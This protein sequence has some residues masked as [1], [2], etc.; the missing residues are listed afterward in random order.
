MIA[1][2]RMAWAIGLGWIV[3]T[4]EFGYA[5]PIYE[6][7][8]M[9]VW[10]YIR[11]GSETFLFFLC[12]RSM[13]VFVQGAKSERARSTSLQQIELRDVSYAHDLPLQLLLAR[14]ISGLLHQVELVLHLLGDAGFGDDRCP[15]HPF[16]R[17]DS[18]QNDGRQDQH[19]NE[20]FT[21]A[22]GVAQ[23]DIQSRFSIRPA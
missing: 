14:A 22:E 17:R 4:A 15:G 19:Q 1:T 2:S 11:I 9:E 7:L 5:K 12:F 8:T 10:I 21:R 18:A 20:C 6:F 23:I 13:R 16:D 3:Y